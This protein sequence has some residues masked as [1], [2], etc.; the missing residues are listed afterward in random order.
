M[1][2]QTPREGRGV[3]RAASMEKR[4][5]CFQPRGRRRA[6]R[7]AT[8]FGVFAMFSLL[9]VGCA[10]TS[11]HPAAA[12][13]VDQP[14][15]AAAVSTDLDGS[16]DVGGHRLHLRCR[17]QGTPTLVLDAGSPDSSTSWEPVEDE[18]AE[19][20]RTC[21]YDR[22]GLGESDPSPGPR[23]SGQ[24][25]AELRALLAAAGVEPPWVGVGHSFGGLNLRLLAR[26]H[27]EE[28]AALVL[29]DP[30]HEAFVAA[31][32]EL[33][34]AEQWEWFQELE[35]HL[36]EQLDW[37]ATAA[38][39]AAAPPLRDI[40]L[41]VLAAGQPPQEP[42]PS[43]PGSF[44]G[45]EIAALGRRLTSAIAEE[46]AQ[47]ELVVAEESGHYVHADQPELVVETVR[48]VVAAVRATGSP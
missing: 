34:T 43:F 28:V 13:P 2:I 26:L 11:P 30:S 38:E 6:E 25:V 15:P 8:A 39:L 40:P 46:S 37:T 10:T 23:T 12:P 45:P 18:L 48:R 36:P 7:A 31:A 24:M 3:R 5:P 33:L 22:A 21:L 16:F 9:A 29:V 47:G 42:P 17:G 44:P 4:P 41:V 35:R 19:L 14:A 1:R 27:P 32:R 20:T